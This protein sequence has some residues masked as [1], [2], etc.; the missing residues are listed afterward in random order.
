MLPAH[1]WGR[2][3]L[4]ESVTCGA[5]ETRDQTHEA[6]HCARASSSRITISETRDRISSQHTGRSQDASMIMFLIGHESIMQSANH[7]SLD[8]ARRV[9]A[10]LDLYAGI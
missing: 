8:R 6:W 1:T 3:P 4:R 10:R 9:R 2:A 7:A 5:S